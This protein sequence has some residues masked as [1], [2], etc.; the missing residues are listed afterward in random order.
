MK[1]RHSHVLL[2]SIW[3]VAASASLLIGAR[4]AL[5]ADLST[6]KA[7]YAEASYDEALKQLD[8]IDPGTD[9][10]QVHQYRALCLLALGRTRDAER[11][12]EAIVARS[13]LYRIDETQVSPRLVGM[14]RE[15]RR[16]ALPEAALERYTKAKAAYEAKEYETSSRWFRDV[17]AIVADPDAAGEQANL[18]DMK[19]LAEGFLVLAKAAAAP[20]PAPAAVAP[21]VAAPPAPVVP[22]RPDPPTV[23]T[24][25]DRD[26]VAPVDIHR[27]IP[28]WRPAMGQLGNIGRRGLLEIVIDEKGSV[29]SAVIARPIFPSYDPD[30]LTAT[31]SWRFKPAT[32]NGKPVKYRR[33]IEI[34]LQPSGRQE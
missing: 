22:R 32:H 2:V 34:V 26:V 21:P 20:P 11:S 28:G 13:P 5:A 3:S 14:F 18:A 24:S 9:P 27:P 17:I 30:L 25:D 19:Q 16:R 12:L 6:V 29:E 31:R 33:V 10:D 15:I 8:A 7:L 23:F 4:P 1:K